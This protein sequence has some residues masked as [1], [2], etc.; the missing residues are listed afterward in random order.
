MNLLGQFYDWGDFTDIG[1]QDTSCGR[2]EVF[3]HPRSK[4]Y[5]SESLCRFN[6]SNIVRRKQEV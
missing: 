1:H 4:D 5:Y 2:L 6:K 3:P